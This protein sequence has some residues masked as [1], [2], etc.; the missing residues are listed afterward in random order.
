MILKLVSK[1]FSFDKFHAIKEKKNFIFSP[2]QA[3]VHYE[4][5]KKKLA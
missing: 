4:I 3:Q 5:V 1:N 2:F